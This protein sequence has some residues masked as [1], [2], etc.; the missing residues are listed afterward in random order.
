MQPHPRTAALALAVALAAG[1]GCPLIEAQPEDTA[2][3]FWEALVADDLA[4]AR[5]LSTAPSEERLAALLGRTD[6]KAAT[7][8]AALRNETSALVETTIFEASGAAALAFN[9]HLAR[10]DSGW[11]VDA[12]ATGRALRQARV[13]A[14]LGNLEEALEEGGR[15]LEEAIE[16][17]VRE[18]GDALREALE[19]IDRALEQSQQDPPI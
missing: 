4:A 6:L 11:R 16:Q 7:V 19:E 14:A 8:G 3:G 2:R 1:V 5:G 12:E 9:T 17:G 10:F 15:V 18:A 13:A